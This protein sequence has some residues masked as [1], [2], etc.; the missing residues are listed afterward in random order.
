MVLWQ[1]GQKALVENISR[2]SNQVCGERLCFCQKHH[3]LAVLYV[4]GGQ[5]SIRT[6]KL[7][8]KPHFDRK[9]KVVFT[10]VGLMPERTGRGFPS[11]FGLNSAKWL[12]DVDMLGRKHAVI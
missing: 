10:V 11:G 7:S 1:A 8:I 9:R 4:C 12:L 5:T 6:G 2:K 3:Q